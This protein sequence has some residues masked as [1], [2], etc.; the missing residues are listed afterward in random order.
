MVY[1]E[2]MHIFSVGVYTG[3]SSESEE[4]CFVIE[5]LHDRPTGG[6]VISCPVGI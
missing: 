5:Q 3:C 6:L 2:M 1:T 4:A